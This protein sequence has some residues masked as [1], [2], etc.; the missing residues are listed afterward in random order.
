MFGKKKESD[1]PEAAPEFSS[2]R[3]NLVIERQRPQT[4]L[5]AGPSRAAS[6]TPGAANRPTPPSAAAAPAAAEKSPE[7]SLP[8]IEEVRRPSDPNKPVTPPIHSAAGGSA[9]DAGGKRLSVGKGISLSGEIKNCEHLLVEGEI[10]A[11]LNDCTSLEIAKEGVFKGTA[12]VQNAS[13]AG[14][15]DG[16][17]KVKGCLTIKSGGEVKGSIAY[18]DLAIERGGKLR[19]KLEELKG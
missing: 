6:P 19:G 5:P 17:I 15:F 18:G 13:V 2:Q 3:D 7:P 10:E 4:P 14:T 11:T 12:E 8:A 1:K 16:E 9:P